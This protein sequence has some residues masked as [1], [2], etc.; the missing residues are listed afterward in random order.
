MAAFLF[1]AHCSGVTPCPRGLDIQLLTGRHAEFRI[2]GASGGMPMEALFSGL[3]CE[4]RQ[5]SSGHGVTGLQKTGVI[6]C[7][8]RY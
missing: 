7:R 4:P 6:G 5:V 8:K 1:F 3:T 2:G